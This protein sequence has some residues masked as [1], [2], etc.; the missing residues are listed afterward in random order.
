MSFS[1]GINGI[2]S[3]SQALDVIGNNIANSQTVG[4][5]SSAISFSDIF[6]GAIGLGSQT[7]GI[8]QNFENGSMLS[9]AKNLDLAISGNGFFR[10]SDNGGQVY[11]TRNGEFKLNSNKQ[12]VNFQNKFLTGYQA[13][14]NP[15]SI[16]TGSPIENI[17]LPD[18]SMYPMASTKG[19]IQGNLKS[20]DVP[21]KI[22]QFQFNNPD[23]YNFT[24]QLEAYDSL[25]KKHIIKIFYVKNKEDGN[26]TVNGY[27]ETA[28]IMNGQNIDI[29]SVSISFDENGNLKKSGEIYP[30]LTIPSSSI[31]GSKAFEV[32]ISMNQLIQQ[33][34]ENKIYNQKI[35][36]Y[37]VGKFIDYTISNSGKIIANYSNGQTQLIAQIVMA[38]FTN[39]SG[40]KSTGENCWIETEES[41]AA[42]LGTSESGGFGQILGKKLESSNV[43]ISNELV[44]MMIQQSNYQS[45]AQTIKTQDQLLQVLVNMR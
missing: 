40:L 5:K 42:T 41:G 43:D 9:S 26:W 20:N 28:P 35:D 36:G 8:T 33:E 29:K 34:S 21:P 13:T 10:L 31:N 17:F 39:P 30:Q 38:N 19:S 24:S 2:N 15:P 3:A 23:S 25:G 14:G 4:F 7:S 16:S 27:D 45:N 12:I 18:D 44:K 32:T 1:Q 37:G 6:S 22:E 11:F